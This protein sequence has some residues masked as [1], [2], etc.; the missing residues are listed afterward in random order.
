MGDF[1]K[2]TRKS[3]GKLCKDITDLDKC[4]KSIG[5]RK[6]YGPSS[7]TCKGTCDFINEGDYKNNYKDDNGEY[8]MFDKV[9]HTKNNIIRICKD[10]KDVNKL[11]AKEEERFDMFV[12]I[13]GEN[14]KPTLG[15]ICCEIGKRHD[16][17][18]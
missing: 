14:Y 6:D 13:T 8:I 5:C 3:D 9:N 16:V 10:G 1:K 4:E 15:K 11:T 12:R 2:G 7:T 17:D 18:F